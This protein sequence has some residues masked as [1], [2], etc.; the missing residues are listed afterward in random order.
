M[1]GQECG[2]FHTDMCPKQESPD[3]AGMIQKWIEHPVWIQLTF[4]LSRTHFMSLR[5]CICACLCVCVFVCLYACLS[6]YMCVYMHACPYRHPRRTEVAVGCSQLLLHLVFLSQGLSLI[7][8]LIILGRPGSWGDSVHCHSWICSS[9]GIQLGVLPHIV[10]ALP[11][12][13][14]PPQTFCFTKGNSCFLFLF[15]KN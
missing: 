4:Y 14:A 13:A 12:W 7:A 15:F 9:W 8:E 2:K 3:G 10:Q 11:Y 5:V 6:V 1:L